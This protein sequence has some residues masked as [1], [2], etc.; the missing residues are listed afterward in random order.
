MEYIFATKLAFIIL[1]ALG[2]WLYFT[3]FNP[4]PKLVNPTDQLNAV[5]IQP[6][7]ALLIAESLF[8]SDIRQNPSLKTYI[9]IQKTWFN[10]F[11]FVCKRSNSVPSLRSYMDLDQG[12]I[13]MNAQ[14]GEII[15]HK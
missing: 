2:F 1:I 15:S 5:K 10:H 6:K 11:Y 12:I 3:G 14:T 8:S 13:K 9:L 4:T 7:E